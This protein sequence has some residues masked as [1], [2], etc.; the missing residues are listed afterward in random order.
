MASKESRLSISTKCS[1]L[2]FTLTLN[3]AYA[4]DG[5]EEETHQRSRLFATSRGSLAVTFGR[6]TNPTPAGTSLQSHRLM[7]NRLITSW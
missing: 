6:N 2:S 7:P 1:E 4:V 5:A 3:A